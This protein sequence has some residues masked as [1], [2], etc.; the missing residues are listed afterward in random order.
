MRAH[1]G[2]EFMAEGLNSAC[3]HCGLK[4]P[5]AFGTL[6]GEPPAQVQ[7]KKRT[8][9]EIAD[10]LSAYQE[11]LELVEAK[12]GASLG[13]L[14]YD[15]S[16]GSPTKPL[17]AERDELKAHLERIGKELSTKTDA[18][19]G[20]IRRLDSDIDDIKSEKAR[21]TAK[22]KAAEKALEWL[23]SYILS[24]M[25]QNSLTRLKTPLNTISI[26]KNGGKQ[27]LSVPHPELVPDELCEVSVRM[28]AGTWKAARKLMADE[29][30]GMDTPKLLIGMDNTLER[31]PNNE[32]IRA[33]L[34]KPCPKC[35]GSTIGIAGESIQ[36]GAC[37]ECLGT[38]KCRI[39]GAK[40]EPRAERLDVR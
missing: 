6:C 37:S 2:H 30:Y 13:E 35:F 5:E 21:L 19:A 39:S 1:D 27:A 34:E 4:V 38:G 26:V 25:Q 18:C 10:D 20:V 33:E 36:D 9:A 14:A 32:A 17:L 40:L 12:I 11:T 28:G 16:E 24:S 31:I 22:Q 15:N 8:F 29:W 23:K 7:A 3:I